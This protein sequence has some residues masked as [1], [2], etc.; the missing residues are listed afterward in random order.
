MRARQDDEE[1]RAWRESV[2]I[3]G[4]DDA[5]WVEGK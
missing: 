5:K 1:S 2:S 3:K 4:T